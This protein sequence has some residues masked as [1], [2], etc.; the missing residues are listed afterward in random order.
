[1]LTI[2]WD[3]DDVLNDLMLQWFHH[4]W[5]P[6][7]PECTLSFDDLLHNPPH[8]ILGTEREDYLASMDQFR[9]T[10]RGLELTPNPGILDWF[11][12]HGQTFRHIALTARPL[13]TAPDVAAWV[14]RHFGTWIRCFGVVPSRANGGAP[15]YDRSKIDFLKWLGCG[16]ILVDDADEN[17]RDAVSLGMRTFQIA[18]PWNKSTL[19]SAAL[20]SK[21]SDLAARN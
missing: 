18:Q 9:R 8:K 2:V 21:L 13:E 7:H 4:A 6:E 16:D 19:T 14:M 5:K 15:V 3:V 17:I 10:G 20:G 11:V 1:M 12:Q